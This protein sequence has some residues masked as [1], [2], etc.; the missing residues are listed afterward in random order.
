MSVSTR[1]FK[2]SNRLP[3]YRPL[4]WGTYFKGIVAKDPVLWLS[5]VLAA[6]S[7]AFV[8]PPASAYAEAVDFK[9][10][11]CLACLMTASGGFMISGA[12]DAVAAR[13][14]AACG[15]E[16]GLTASMVAGTFFSSMFITNDV[17]LI[18]F[19]PMALIAFRR[20]GCDPALTVVLQ[21]VAANVGSILLPMGN[22][23]N[24]Y[25]Y[26]RYAMTFAPFF[27]TVLPL[28]LAGAAVLAV[29]CLRVKKTAV[30]C[31]KAAGAEMSPHSIFLYTF[32]FLI[33]VLA[34]FDVFD[35][36]IALGLCVVAMFVKGRGLAQ[37][38]DYALLL[39][40]VFFFVFVG[41]IARVPAVDE[42]LTGI[43][44]P[45]PYF[46]AVAASQV[47]SN[48]PA[49]VLLSR[50]TEDGH[51]LLAGVSAG[52]CGTLIASMASLISYK[53]FVR[54]G[55][56][57]KRYLTLFFALNVLFLVVMTLARVLAE[58]GIL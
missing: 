24:L 22:P 34:V 30:N 52:G 5:A 8:R 19:V 16:R 13:L 38:I 1:L 39:T 26:S 10:L 53:L 17:A 2:Q 54:D 31:P 50:F 41:N 56:G 15:S 35:Y 23:Q 21:T 48:V 40:F 44:A 47:I 12:F 51:A 55:G 42:A 29:F 46:A 43:V 36:R 58:K 32:L 49:A 14:V 7:S 3:K 6:A 27:R 28:S 18:V 33:A 45:H 57:R 25:L 4:P 20:A 9:T 37:Q 11:A